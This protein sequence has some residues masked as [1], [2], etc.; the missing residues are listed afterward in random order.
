MAAYRIVKPA[1]RLGHPR[2]RGYHLADDELA[3]GDHFVIGITENVPDHRWRESYTTI[4]RTVNECGR[5]PI[6][7]R[8]F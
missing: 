3:P 1:P 8:A 6:N 5:L 7:P 4:L 2:A